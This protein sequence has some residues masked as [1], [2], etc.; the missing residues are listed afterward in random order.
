MC[1]CVTDT[2]ANLSRLNELGCRLRPQVPCSPLDELH[3]Y[4][5]DAKVR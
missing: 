2:A 3:P 4:L 1:Q 5:T